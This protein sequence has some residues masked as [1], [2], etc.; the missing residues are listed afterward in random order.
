MPSAGDDFTCVITSDGKAL[1]FGENFAGQ[2]LIPDLPLDVWYVQVSCGGEHTVLLRSDGMA[3]A[4]G[5]TRHGQCNIPQ[6]SVGQTYTQASAGYDHTVLL[7]SDGRVLAIGNN[8][9][10]QCQVHKLGQLRRVTRRV[11][12]SFVCNWSPPG[13]TY[14]QVSAGYG[15]TVLLC[16]DGTVDTCGWNCHGQRDIPKQRHQ[17][18]TYTHIS[19]GCH[20]TGLI[21]SDGEAYI[22]EFPR[23]NEFAT[24]LHGFSD[25]PEVHP[26]I[27]QLDHGV[28]YTQISCGREHTILIRSDGQAIGI[29]CNQYGQIAIP[30]LPDGVTYEQAAAGKYHTVLLRSDGRAVAF[31][32]N[33]SG[34][35]ELP[36]LEEG[37]SLVRSSFIPFCKVVQV[38]LCSSASSE[39]VCTN[40]VTSQ[41]LAQI[42]VVD[43]RAPVRYSVMRMIASPC[44][45][46]CVML[47]DR[48]LAGS[49]LTW[50]ELKLGNQMRTP[51]MAQRQLHDEVTDDC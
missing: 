28:D 45:R 19:A 47:P 10:G 33:I 36:I 44:H 1:A 13:V 8:S 6:L 51:N 30:G 31:G 11:S 35:T 34:G 15:H 16:E 40:A 7:R 42:E 23:M 3:V 22:S 2:C 46:V 9:V 43:L 32:R 17:G 26:S 18:V 41:E 48:R 50:S 39:V 27:P 29:G 20:G 5:L 24:P 25:M 12:E 38:H 49:S 14:V 4:C 21:R 37:V